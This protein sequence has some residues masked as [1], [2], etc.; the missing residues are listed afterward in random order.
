MRFFYG[1]I[2]EVRNNKKVYSARVLSDFDEKDE[3]Y[4]LELIRPDLI[5]IGRKEYHKGD[6]LPNI[7]NNKLQ[8]R[9]LYYVGFED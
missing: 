9:I 5:K 2:L 6:L 4:P 8:L 3:N 1:D 7:R